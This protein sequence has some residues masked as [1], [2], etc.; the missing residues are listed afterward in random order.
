MGEVVCFLI[1]FLGPVALMMW[2]GYEMAM[3]GEK[4]K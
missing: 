2:W 3:V 4:K 1:A